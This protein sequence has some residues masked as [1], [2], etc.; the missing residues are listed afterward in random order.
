MRF[1]KRNCTCNSSHQI[2]GLDQLILED[3]KEEVTAS[4]LS[5][6]QL[7]ANGGGVHQLLNGS[8][9]WEK[10][11]AHKENPRWNQ[12]VDQQASFVASPDV[13]RT[14]HNTTGYCHYAHLAVL[15]FFLFG[16]VGKNKTRCFSALGNLRFYGKIDGN[17]G[18]IL[19]RKSWQCLS[20]QEK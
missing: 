4:G 2:W 3:T 16:D 11:R 10:T 12:P 15:C 8:T 19:P 5:F 20:G 1:L 9:E 18:L 6:R 17:F 13:E 14:H 7:T